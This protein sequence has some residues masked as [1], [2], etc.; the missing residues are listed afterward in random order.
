MKK[1]KESGRHAKG[2]KLRKISKEEAA[3]VV[4]EL[5]EGAY[6]ELNALLYNE[7]LWPEYLDLNVTNRGRMAKNGPDQDNYEG[8]DP[9][10]APLPPS[11]YHGWL[12]PAVN[13]I[14]GIRNTSHYNTYDTHVSLTHANSSY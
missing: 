11:Q 14:E 6:S 9:E 13:P 12:T 3:E 2:R 1:T 8:H 5:D 10:D 7:L 4:A